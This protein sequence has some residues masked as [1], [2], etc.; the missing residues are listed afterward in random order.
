MLDMVD[1]VMVLSAGANVGLSKEII[2][3][4]EIEMFVM[5]LS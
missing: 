3:G 5:S 1:N 4:N 2:A